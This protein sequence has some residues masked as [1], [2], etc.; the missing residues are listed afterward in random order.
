MITQKARPKLKYTS[1]ERI[2]VC[3]VFAQAI[4]D[5]AT[6]QLLMSIHPL[7]CLKQILKNAVLLCKYN[8]Y[9]T[10]NNQDDYTNADMKIYAVKP[11]LTF[12]KIYTLY[13]YLL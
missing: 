11:T 4:A 7:H 10:S 9:M 3:R 2:V 5:H 12:I 13:Y 8:V 1:T 6:K